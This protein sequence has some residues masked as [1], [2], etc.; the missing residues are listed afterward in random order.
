MAHPIIANRAGAQEVLAAQSDEITYAW[1]GAIVKSERD[2]DARYVFGKAT[3]GTIDSDEQIVDPAFAKKA[4]AEWFDSAANVR[5]MHSTNLP[6]AGKGVSLDS[7]PDG[8]YVRTKVVE[9]GA[10]R[11][12]DEGV[13]T[14]YSV[15]ISRPKIERDNKARGGR[16]TGGRIVELSLVDRPANPLAKFEIAKRAKGGAVEFVGKSVDLTKARKAE[17]SVANPKPGAKPT[18]DAKPDDAQPDAPAADAKPV[19]PHAQADSAPPADA[20]PPP[21]DDKPKPGSEPATSVS[22][23]E[24]AADAGP[25]ETAEKG[26]KCAKCMG[27]GKIDDSDCATCGGTGLTKGVDAED[28]ADHGADEM[29]EKE[30]KK[31]AKK[32]AKDA[33]EAIT[34]ITN[35]Q[36]A[37]DDEDGETPYLIRRLHDFSCAAYKTADVLDRYPAIQK[38]GVTS[39][40]G[41]STRSTIYATLCKA[42]K[43][44]GGD[45]D[46]AVDILRIGKIYRTFEDF[47]ADNNKGELVLA[48]REQLHAAFGEANKIDVLG[49]DLS[50]S[51]PSPSDSISPSSFRRPYLSAGHQRET[52]QSSA[53]NIPTTTHPID[54]EDYTRGPLTDGHARTLTEKLAD[55]HD[56]VTDWRPNLCLMD[57]N[58]S[59][60]FDRQP[61]DPAVDRLPN[62]A[63]SSPVSKDAMQPAAA[64]GEKSFSDEQLENL[65]KKVVEPYAN[66]ISKL[67]K[68]VERMAAEP[69]P[70][71]SALRG[72]AGQGLTKVDRAEKVQR[73]TKSERRKERKADFLQSI[74]RSGSPEQRIAAE[75]RLS[76]LGFDL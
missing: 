21:P 12:V 69:D 35:K 18:P 42:L 40:L 64:P 36:A 31:A 11:L 56:V 28:V 20:G 37:A 52:A 76:K 49:T 6:P 13:Y 1:L 74:A 39:A 75:E 63:T 19:P 10:V 38:N 73:S 8:E 25:E 66:Q 16:I 14:G 29:T 65:L 34:D 46:L 59:M 17:G 54:A 43:E 48:A 68:T 61:P 23:Q 32:A 24:P 62:K 26:A 58:G 9:P 72:V 71:R 7:R 70:N 55:L 30:A 27:S 4:L 50:P 60:A 57:A 15:G 3:D 2:G 45:G 47:I 41:S 44:D 67:E 22:D 51:I 33:R 5:Q 53:A